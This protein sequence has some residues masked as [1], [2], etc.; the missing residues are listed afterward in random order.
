MSKFPYTCIKV[1]QTPDSIPLYVSTAKA[2]ELL[3]WCDVPR[4]KEGFMAGYQRE[5]EGRHEKITEFF[6]QDPEHNIV[7]NA[8]IVAIDQ[9]RLVIKEDG[10]ICH[11]T[12][13]MEESGLEEML[14]SLIKQFEKRLSKEELESIEL[15]SGDYAEPDAE[16]SDASIPP[17][18][19]LA[20]LTKRLR[21]MRDSPEDLSVEQKKSISDYAMSVGRPGLIIDGQHRVFGAKEVVEFDVEFPVVFIP[22]LD[23]KEQVFHF[24]VLNNK[25]K[26]LNRTH[27][28]RIISTTLSKSEIEK[29]YDRLRDAGVEAKSAEW[30][31]RMNNDSDSPFR[32][33]I[34]MGLQGSTGVISENVAYQVVSKFMLL[35]NRYRLLTENVSNWDTQSNDYRLRAFY[36]VWQAVKDCYPTAW[37]QA[38]NQ[39]AA[40]EERQIF[41]KVS[42]ITLQQYILDTLNSEMPKRRSKGHKSPFADLV[43]LKSEVGY[44]LPFLKEEFFMKPWKLT[45]LDTSSGHDIFRKT[46]DKAI[47]N[48][49]KNLGN[50]SLFKVQG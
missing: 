45:G 24:Y 42:L 44:A 20:E 28:R 18:S 46:L 41:F 13:A 11:L 25:A 26:P 43:E 6:Q 34:D 4:S 23:F 27:L 38:E 14:A 1:Q 16:E 2:N 49:S 9:S 19:Y 39:N 15:E 48:E 50:M 37:R 8:V 29:L 22:G 3:R 30:T 35:H 47:Q 21:E 33:L 17:A 32:G 7:P 40:N 10:R 36:T 31:H 12:I 5:L